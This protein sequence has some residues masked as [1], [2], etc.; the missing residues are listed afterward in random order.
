MKLYFIFFS[1]FVAFA[2][3]GQDSVI[4]Q[5][6]ITYT[7]K[8]PAKAEKNKICG[9]VLIE[10]DRN[11]HGNFSNPVLKKG[12]GYGCDEEAMRITK[13]MIAGTNACNEKCKRK[14]GTAGKATQKIKFECPVDD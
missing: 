2:S 9:D 10:L 3:F 11:E 1:L 4:C 13:I 12:L 6:T 14:K 8:Y 7:L 5:C